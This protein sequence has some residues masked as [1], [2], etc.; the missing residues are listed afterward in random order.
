MILGLLIPFALLVGAG[1]LIPRLLERVMPETLG[2]LILNGILSSVALLVVSAGY[3]AVAYYW[4]STAVFDLF[5]IAPAATV[6]HF[7]RLGIGAAVIW[8]PVV[9]LAVSTAPRRWKENEW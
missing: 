2:G 5:G 6:M 4:R 1:I 7:L 3:F 9:V 8:A